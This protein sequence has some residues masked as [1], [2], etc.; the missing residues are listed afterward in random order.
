MRKNWLSQSKL[1]FLTQIHQVWKWFWRIYYKKNNNIVCAL[2]IQ[3]L[4]TSYKGGSGSTG[5]PES[6]LFLLPRVS[7]FLLTCLPHLS[8][9][10]LHVWH[11]KDMQSLQFKIGNL[12]HLVQ[13]SWWW[14]KITIHKPVRIL[15]TLLLILSFFV[16][17]FCI[18]DHIKKT[19]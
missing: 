15:L 13:R 3:K 19:Y 12:P 2:N 17:G 6:T 11:V 9:I 7:L 5:G 8:S 14:N 10:L 4:K 18:T 1:K 16:N